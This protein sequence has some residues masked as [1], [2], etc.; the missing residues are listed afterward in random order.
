MCSSAG[1]PKASEQVLYNKAVR[2]SDAYA[3]QRTK[4]WQE[5]RSQ[6]DAEPEAKR[7]ARMR[8]R[9]RVSAK[10]APPQ[11]DAELARRKIYFCLSAIIRTSH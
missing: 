4:R 10:Y 11:T 7:L 1:R 5:T 8:V 2:H 3:G 6:V 9:R